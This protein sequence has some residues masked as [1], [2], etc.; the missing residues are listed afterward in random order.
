[1]DIILKHIQYLSKYQKKIQI[2]KATCKRHSLGF[3][4]APGNTADNILSC[5]KEKHNH[6]KDDYRGCRHEQFLKGAAFVGKNLQTVRQSSWAQVCSNVERPDKGVP[7]RKRIQKDDCK[8]RRLCH[9]NKNAPQI[10]PVGSSVYSCRIIKAV[11]NCVK[12]VSQNVS[13][14]NTAHKRQ[15][16]SRNCIKKM[17]FYNRSVI[18][19]NQHFKRNHHQRK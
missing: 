13:I 17:K 14:K 6:R 11:R 12:K 9:W 10:H 8:Q 4:S 16:Q 15:N 7:G 3:N 5:N 19:D 1:M 18:C 2:L